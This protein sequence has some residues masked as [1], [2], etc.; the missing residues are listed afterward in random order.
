M[1][2]IYFFKCSL[3]KNLLLLIGILWLPQMLFSQNRRVESIQL[4]YENTSLLSIGSIINFGIIKKIKNGKILK[5]RG[6]AGGKE[7]WEDFQIQAEG[8]NISNGIFYVNTDARKI[9]KH[10]I[11]LKVW[12]KDDASKA[13]SVVFKLNYEGET[14]ANFKPN[15]PG[16]P[17]DRGGRILPI[18]I[19]GSGSDGKDGYKGEDGYPG[20]IVDVYV[21]L[22]FDSLLNTSLLKVY[23]KN[24]IGTR[25]GRYLIHPEKGFLSVLA[26]GG[27]GA[28]GGNGGRGVDGKDRSDKNRS[29]GDG[30][31]GG[32]GGDGGNG[33]NGGTVTVYLDPSA[34]PYL[35]KIKIY[36]AGG[37][38]GQGGNGGRGG[39]GGGGNPPGNG[40][41]SGENGRNGSEGVNGPPPQ[42]IIQ[43]VV[44]DW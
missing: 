27:D 39:D 41:S 38:G 40:G 17:D 11:K 1:T 36:N 3:P 35:E 24:K 22:A 4:V 5:T 34:E 31:N 25:E 16:T 21:K 30:S 8:G 28:N 29:G 6:F 44:L 37:Q 10:Q 19:G 43:E 9:Q 15:T 42:I 14:L 23:V 33:G 18:K 12:L 20:D 13:D 7:D 2:F 32:R 26:E